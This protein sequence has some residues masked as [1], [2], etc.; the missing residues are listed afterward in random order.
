M[1][2]PLLG[3]VFTALVIGG[4]VYAMAKANRY[5]EA[6]REYRRKREEAERLGRS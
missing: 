4:G 6:E 5:Q 3:I 2:F 1:L